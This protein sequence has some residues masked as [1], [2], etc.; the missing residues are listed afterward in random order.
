MLLFYQM[1][2]SSTSEK[3]QK[4]HNIGANIVNLLLAI[5]LFQVVCMY[6]VM[7]NVFNF[8]FVHKG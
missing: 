3:A 2:T 1:N 8:S 7:L 4:S 6:V 5:S